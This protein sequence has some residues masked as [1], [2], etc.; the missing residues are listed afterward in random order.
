[1]TRLR[2]LP[3]ALAC[4]SVWACTPALD[5][6]ETQPEGAGI[7]V[8]FPC[9]PDRHAR[10]VLVAGAK[11]RME[12][13]VCA[14]GGATYALSFVDAVNPA[15]V[16]PALSDLRALAVR[17][18]GGVEPRWFD[19][20]VRGMTPNPQATRLSLAGRLP[21]GAPVL[22]EAAFFARGLRVYQASVVGAK[23]VPEATQTFFAG[24][25]LPA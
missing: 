19:L 7:V 16:A 21:D 23:L 12:M 10:A 24:L 14:A 2:A 3:V 25:R 18:L 17:N 1:M 6:R 13:W 15:G 8:M 22:Q 5:W 20:H 11:V 4:A 9:R